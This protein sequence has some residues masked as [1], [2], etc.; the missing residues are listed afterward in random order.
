MKTTTDYNGRKVDI[1]M[2]SGIFDSIEWSIPYKIISG[3][4]KLTQLFVIQFFSELGSSL[5]EPNSG[6]SFM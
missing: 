4:A 6:S 2:S 5:V 1:L 3:V